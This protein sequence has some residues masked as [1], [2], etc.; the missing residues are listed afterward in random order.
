MIA[1][2]HC[3]KEVWDI[4]KNVNTEEA[5]QML[6]HC[7]VS[8]EKLS[9][10]LAQS[11]NRVLADNLMSKIPV[12]PFDRSPFDGFVFR[13]ED[14]FG[15]TDKSPSVLRIIEEIAAGQCGKYELK[16]GE[17]A[18]ILTGAP[19]PKGGNTTVK[20]EDTLFTDTHVSI[21]SPGTPGTN[22]VYQGSDIMPNSPIARSGTIITPAIISSV[23]NQGFSHLTVYKKPTITILSTGSELC[24]VGTILGPASIYNSN[25]H[26]ISAY[27]ADVGADGVSGGSVPDD[28]DLIAKAVDD[29][30][31]V[32]DMVI[33][34][35]GASVGD[36]DWAVGAMERLGAKILFW[37]A[38]MRP[39]GA[40]LAGIRDGKVILSL[41][42]NPAAAVLGL[43]RIGIPYIKK[44]CGRSDCFYPQVEVRLKEPLKKAS[45]KLRLIRG[46][47]E[48]HNGLAYFSDSGNQGSE[49]VS[50]LARCD[51]LGEIPMGSPPLP[52]ETIIKAYRI[53]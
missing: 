8:V 19:I 46:T 45:P 47:L 1:I 44:L 14:T 9:V 43:M 31:K 7:D 29:A 20:Y 12:P 6:Y 25:V 21:L 38:A 53:D 26:T 52:A 40:I 15:A 32:S 17:A 16:K 28:P 22:I 50:S 41:S 24:E 30:L 13:G 18:K 10:T 27:L 2:N 5:C 3:P 51:L 36:Y 48:I 37:K 49:A 42:G 23:A 4:L 33:T 34:T 35:G 39:G 11:Q